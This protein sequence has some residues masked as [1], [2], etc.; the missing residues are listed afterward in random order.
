[1]KVFLVFVFVL[2]SAFSPA[3]AAE[4]VKAKEVV[5]TATK[6]EAEIED[7]PATV[8]V[9][10]KEEIKAKGAEKLRDII[11]LAISVYKQG[12]MAREDSAVSIRG[13]KPEQTLILIDGRRIT[14]EVSLAYEID[15][16][17]LENVERIEIVR[18]PA[19]ALYGTDALGGV[20]NIITKSPEKFSFEFA[21]EYGV[22][23]GGKGE[24][25]SYSARL[26]TGKL[27]KFGFSLS[28]SLINRNPFIAQ[29]NRYLVSDA[30]HKNF[31]M[32]GTYDFTKNTALIFD[33][34]Y[35]KEDSVDKAPGRMILDRYIDDNTRY[36]LSLGLSHRSPQ[37]DYLIRAYTS[38]YDKDYEFRNDSTGAL[39]DFTE[40][41]RNTTVL[42][43]KV[44][45]EF[46]KKHLLTIGA[47][48][49]H[50]FFKGTR[51]ATG[52]GTYSVTRE[53]VTLI[54]SEAKLNYWAGYIQDE[55]QVSDAL[56]IIPA[57]RYDDSD[58]FKG[59][60]SPKLGITYKL[61]PDL[62][63]KLNYG[64]GFK[65]PTP[66]E[67]YLDFRH[68][69][70][71]YRI[72]G[73]PNV[74]PEK[75]DSYEIAL[76][77]ERGIFSGR[78]AYFYN[79]VEDLITTTQVACPAGT[80]A[81][82]TCYQYVNINKAEI[83]G[84]EIEAGARLSKEMSLKAAYSHLIAKDKDTG[85]RLTNRTRNKVVAKSIYD[86]KPAGFKA[87]LWWEYLDGLLWQ[88]NPTVEKEYGLWYLSLSK[89]IAKNLELYAG[90]DNLFD[91]KDNDIPL[92]GAF[93]YGGVRM[94]F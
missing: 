46:F 5:V 45:K 19:S 40:A 15:R 16:I 75:S 89:D 43:G 60:I 49:R 28:G 18:G 35:M 14:G 94:K 10:T 87:N 33:A 13:F 12:F 1:M 44:T 38:I 91:K 36:N 66:R 57:L 71:R 93:Y 72:L 47:E 32:K 68:P 25:R 86:N 73:N 22:F 3:H 24:Q 84:I 34:E 82:W 64:H 59:E 78:A 39:I 74:K 2:M 6:T 52:K 27:G 20:I 56:I 41:E 42:E 48:Y 63:V 79:D 4:E 76:E 85:A 92:V 31:A 21:P 50:E 37:I 8:E 88:T 58:K 70:P 61:L 29:D 90:V 51:I 69:G 77:G 53:G 7:V 23:S 83:Q 54:G 55:W 62:R 67:L 9:I 11:G 65:T 26:D 80:P 81:G 17:T 30:E